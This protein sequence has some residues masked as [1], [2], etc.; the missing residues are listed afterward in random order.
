MAAV[1]TGGAALAATATK[2]VGKEIVEEIV[3]E[4]IEKVV[5]ETAE[6]AAEAGSKKALKEGVEALAETKADDIAKV[7]TNSLDSKIDDA[8]KKFDS[9]KATNK[10]KGNFGEMKAYKNHMQN[11][12]LKNIGRKP[13][14][15]L[16][17]KI[18]KGIDGIYENT[19]YPPPPKFIIDEAKYGTSR[20]GKTKSSG[21][22]MSDRWVED[23]LKKQVGD[24]KAR[25]IMKAMKD[26]EVDKI[27][28]KIDKA[29]NVTT[30]KLDALGNVIK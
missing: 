28:S 12:N 4:T 7:V 8:L 29:G 6:E 21:K 17:E 30:Q 19:A 11:P 16:D 25:E 5:K 9:S 2:K 15:N 18:K 22:Q 27:L 1:Y 24:K 13:P 23:R 20:L 10:Q 14:T 26:G 3:E